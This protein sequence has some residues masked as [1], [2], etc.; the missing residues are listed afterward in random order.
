MI[1]TGDKDMAQLVSPHV[2]LVNTMSQTTLDVAGV[3]EKFGVPP[4]LIIDFLA[5]TGDTSDN[6]PGIPG[7]GPKTAA[8]WLTTY[9]SLDAVIAHA[10]EIKGKAGE[11]LRANLQTLA[12]AREL[13]AIRC[14]VELQ[15]EPGSLEIQP[16]D[17][18]A[19]R[20]LYTQLDF[21]RWLEELG[22]DAATLASGDTGVDTTVTYETVLTRARLDDWLQRLSQAG[23]FAF[24]TETTSL[25]YMEAQHRRGVVCP[26]GG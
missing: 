9:G 6:I 2:T 26:P 15:A 11:S 22:G 24:D 18:A 4:G 25:D 10:D 16:Q 7:V 19:L 13:T 17:K 1:S 21:R 20:E 3:E 8:R 12:L 14:D 23:Q 5:L